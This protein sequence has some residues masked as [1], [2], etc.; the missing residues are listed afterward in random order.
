MFSARTEQWKTG[1]ID[2]LAALARERLAPEHGEPAAHFVRQYYLGVAADD[3]AESQPLDLFGAAVAHWTL[4]RRR[5]P[6][7]RKLCVYNPSFEKHGWQS[8]H[9]I[10]EIVTDD[11]PFLVDSVSMALNRHGFTVHL[12]VHPIMRLE[13]DREGDLLSVHDPDANA[14][15]LES[16]IHAEVN[17]ES[18]PHILER[19]KEDLYRTLDDVRMAVEDRPQ[20]RAALSLASQELS[21]RPPVHPAVP[22]SLAFLEWIAQ[23]NFVLL[24]YRDHRLIRSSGTEELAIVAG[25]GLGL[26]R[27]RMAPAISRSF[28]ELPAEVKR[29]ALD[30]YPLIVTKSSSRSTVHRPGYLDYIGVKRFGAKGEVIG[31]HRFLGLYAASAYQSDPKAIPLLRHKI[32][33]VIA[34]SG[35][36]P[37]S[38]SRRALLFILD[39]YPRDE[40]FQIGEDEL[41]QFAME[42]MHL[43]ERQRVRLFVREDPYGRFFS[44]LVFAPRDRFHTELRQRMQAILRSAFDASQV[45]FTVALSESPLARIHFI[46]HAKSGGPADYDVQEIEA[47][48]A[49]ATRSWQDRL[50]EALLEAHGEETGNDLLSRYRDAFPV[51]YREDFSARSTVY[52]IGKIEAALASGHLEMHLFGAPEIIAAELS[53]KLY[54]ALASIPLSDVLPV[55][56]NMGVTVAADRSYEIKAPAAAVWIHEYQLKHDEGEGFDVDAVR[57][58]FQDAFAQV[59][60]GVVENDGFNRLVLRAWLEARQILVL[61]AYCR[62]LRHLGMAFSQSYME[63]CMAHNPGIV[64]MLVDLFQARFDPQRKR[65]AGAVST[66]AAYVEGALD[67]VTSLDEDRILRAAFTLIQATTRTNYFQRDAAGRDKPYLSVKLNPALIPRLPKPRPMFEVFI[68]SAR[69]EGVHLRSGKVARGGVRWSDRR[70]DFRTEVLGLMKAQRVKNALIVPVGAKGGFVVKHPPPTGGPEASRREGAA[71]YEIFI[72]GLLDITD[73]RA[74]ERVVAPRDVVRYDEDDP[75][76]VVAADKGTAAFSDLANAIAREYGFWLG[77]AF[78]SGGSAGYDHKRMGITA[79]GAWEAV[80]HHFRDLGLDV[81]S[82]DF[83]V[84]GIGDMAGDVFGNGMLQSRHIKLIGAFNHQHIFLDPN[85]DPESSYEERR[86]LFAQAGTTWADYDPALISS[87]GGV[88][89]R[90]AKAIALS[91]EIKEALAL[92]A[93]RLTPAE[94]IRALLK[95]PVDLLWNGGIGTFVK[96]HA[97]SH[98][99]IGDRSNDGVR[100]DAH[101]LRCRVIAEGGNLGL[102]QRGRIEYALG[103]G[104]LNTDAIDN[105]GGVDCSDR[106]VNLKIPLNAATARGDLSDKMRNQLLAEMSEEVAGH[107]LQD[108][109]RQVR[110]ISIA[111]AE[112]RSQLEGCQQLMTALERDGLLD[113]TLEA[114]PGEEALAE[115]KAAGLGLTRPEIAVLLAYAKMDLYPEILASDL[116]D[117]PYLASVLERYFPAPLRLRFPQ[118]LLDHRLR[119][120]IIATI[121][122][123]SMV[124]RAGITFGLRMHELT[125]RDVPAI[126][127]AYLAARDVFEVRGLWDEIDRSENRAARAVQIELILETQRLVERATRWFLRR[128]RRPLDIAVAVKQFGPAVQWFGQQL[129]QPVIGTEGQGVARSIETWTRQGVPQ[130]LAVKS[131]RLRSLV[132][133]LDISEICMQAGRELGAVGTVY[134]DLSERLKIDWLRDQI[135]RLPLQGAWQE[136][137]RI[138]AGDELA[139]LHSELTVLVLKAATEPGEGLIDRRSGPFRDALKRYHHLISEIGNAEQCDLAMVTV[140]LAELRALARCDFANAAYGS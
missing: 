14:G 2:D 69:T 114:L 73:N 52:D 107:V 117:E 110:A 85:P 10:I 127:R 140:A 34:R 104:R 26:L 129:D 18:D 36:L 123:N 61:R 125:G 50:H 49:E 65:R 101:E 67:N 118:E 88:Y 37:G 1:L 139:A 74:G 106:E 7:L 41:L 24:G 78:A 94:I 33:R 56:E 38:H 111:E 57:A 47:R 60:S 4:A 80:K 9:T 63:D 30:P 71:Y 126:A 108:C 12:I 70:E 45:D 98:A 6:G 20:M 39:S 79:R 29:L 8:T 72:R 84:V 3:L 13:R 135:E 133:V 138:E 116:P 115:R 15:G 76:L 137:A 48:L 87:G 16:I 132:H 5:P 42:I 28:A 27:E 54:H 55:L 11:M 136:R 43:Q 102:T 66:L 128:S 81:A 77:D 17:R 68:Y 113:R 124:N 91:T 23:D 58:K 82:Q 122:T 95:A 53:F 19:L 119:R 97:E 62:Y 35:L 134:C 103:G 86:R 92:Q 40:L 46:V 21:A 112:A 51:A 130:E 44:C 131:A 99:E 121:V 100:V 89:P 31:E 32:D 90:A 93:E 59:W 64:H 75:Y 22:E 109:Y 96:A 25:S 83:T 105:C 120:E